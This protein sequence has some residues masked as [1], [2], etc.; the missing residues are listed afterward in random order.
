MNIKKAVIVGLGI[1]S[2]YKKILN[3]LFYKVVTIDIDPEKGADYLSISDF[4]KT[5]QQ[6]YD[7]GII[8]LPNFLHYSAAEDLIRAGVSNI[9]V[10]KPGFKNLQEY[11]EIKEFSNLYNVNLLMIKNNY[12]RDEFIQL[13]NFFNLNKHNINSVE[14]NWI[15]GNRIP[16]PGGWFT[17]KELS[18]GG[19]SRDL[20]PHLLHIYHIFSDSYDL[21]IDS[22]KSQEYTLKDIDSAGYGIVNTKNPVYDVDDRC[23]MCIESD[24]IRY[25]IT[26]AWKNFDGDKISVKFY[27]KTNE[28]LEYKFG[29]CPEQAY[30]NMISDIMEE[31]IF[32][33]ENEKHY[34]IDYW[35][36]NLI[37]KI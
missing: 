35:V 30:K 31:K 4:V 15:N 27:F 22:K 8:C 1:G 37:D 18:W 36:Q 19:V 28:T 26:A 32:E 13:K 17:N 33:K 20:I 9:L 29:L 16:N 21:P 7:L 5:E 12:Y 6:I 24:N 34:E 25:Y 3:E 10:E 23:A 11:L 14:I 2:L